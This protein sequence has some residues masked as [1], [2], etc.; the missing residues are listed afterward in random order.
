MAY[1]G[2]FTRVNIIAIF[3][4]STLLF[5]SVA[6]ASYESFAF[7][8]N[9]KSE[10]NLDYIKTARTG[11]FV[12]QTSVNHSISLSESMNLSSPKEKKDVGLTS[13]EDQKYIKSMIIEEE[14]HLSSDLFEEETTVIL[15]KQFSDR[16]GI[17]ERILP[18]D[19]IRIQEK[20]SNKNYLDTNLQ[21]TFSDYNF[22]INKQE[23]FANLLFNSIINDNFNNYI[24][25]SFEAFSKEI[26]NHDF[27]LQQFLDLIHVITNIELSSG[28]FNQI[29]SKELIEIFI[30]V[31]ISGLIFVRTESN[32]IKFNNYRK[33]FS[34]IVIVLL[35]SSGVIT[36]ISISSSYWGTASGEEMNNNSTET[37]DQQI[38]S[39]ENI[40]N[41]LS[42]DY[43][44]SQDNIPENYTTSI[45]NYT[46]IIPENYTTS[47]TNYTDII[48]ENYTTSISNHT[49]STDILENNSMENEVEHKII[50]PNATESWKF[51]SNVNGSHFVGDVY[52]DGESS[53]ILDGDSYVT[54]DGNSTDSISNLTISA[55]VKPYYSNGSSEFTIVSKERTFELII[56]NIIDPQ[57]EAKFSIFV[58][59]QWHSVETSTTLGESWSHL[60]ATF[61]GTKLSVYTNG[62]LSN[63]KSTI[64]TITL[65]TDGQFESKTPGLISSSSDIVVGASL[66]NSRSVDDV[67]KKFSG[68]IYDV[69]IFDVYLT[70]AQIA[71]LYNSSFPFILENSNS[72]NI[73]EVI[74]NIPIE[75][76]K[77]I[78]LL[79]GISSIGLDNTTNIDSISNNTNYDTGIEFNGT[80]N[81]VTINEE[82]LNEDLNQLTIS[83]FI[84]PNYTTGSA[85]FTVL[86]KENSFVLSLNNIL[87]PEH[88]SKFSVFDGISWTEVISSTKIE[89]WTHLVAIINDTRISLYVNGTLEGYAQ[90]SEPIFISGDKLQLTTSDVMVSD[91]D[92]IL[93]AYLSKT[94]GE[95]NLSMYFSGLIDEVFIYKEALTES[96]IQEIYSHFIEQ[97]EPK[98]EPALLLP[99]ELQNTTSTLSHNEIVIGT[100]VNW[101]QTI[102]LNETNKNN[103]Q[104]EL[105]ADAENIQAEI[106]T[107]NDQS[108][109]I[110]SENLEI[111]ESLLESTELIP[112]DIVT[113]E[114]IDEI[115]QDNKDT[116]F[117]VINES[118]SEYMLEFETPAPY[119]KIG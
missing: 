118:A 33:F 13:I 10:N 102:I 117:V 93:G 115:L 32:H 39:F 72:T 46:D 76:L 97:L 116:K 5:S 82:E 78:D 34:Y 3:L 51:D 11:K 109:E 9:A 87:S 89:E 38:N 49:T 83:A 41:T 16:K 67:S 2:S 108:L 85:E 14:L 107:S 71:E 44:N 73:V 27:Q 100:P 96:Q 119:T 20:S 57:Q 103:I 112:L 35:I 77:I 23:F 75:E 60:A 6:N 86:S 84:K 52:V 113:M 74:E 94:R 92:L 26:F 42:M 47:I 55:W 36:P 110:P 21:L 105:P 4:F 45:T 58:G 65:T 114:K 101:I 25:N 111:T 104:V 91:S 7:I 1:W 80:E 19:R 69:N 79:E 28:S 99:I 81:F 24:Y 43:L 66:D 61:N 12:Q 22:Q 88:V 59:I 54:N 64:N 68:E 8:S 98:L 17:M 70:A 30:L 37:T 18:N 29:D 90:L 62:T 53:L 63:E 31:L 48:P 50:L 56:N 15:V 40:T 95:S 106:I